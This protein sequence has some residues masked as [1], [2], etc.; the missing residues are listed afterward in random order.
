M[1]GRSTSDTSTFTTAVNELAILAWASAPG[2]RIGRER[3]PGAHE[4]DGDL[5][6]IV[7][8]RKVDEAGPDGLDAAHDEVPA[9]E[10]ALAAVFVVRHGEGCVG[11]RVVRR[12]REVREERRTRR[13][14]ADWVQSAPQARLAARKRRAVTSA[15]QPAPGLCEP[16]ANPPLR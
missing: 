9:V 3:Q 10:Q 1:S 7:A 4:T 2:A 16:C 13:T 12:G 8:A 11:R 5:E 6:H 14:G 15:R